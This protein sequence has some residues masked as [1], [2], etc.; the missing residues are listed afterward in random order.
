MS[1]HR[2]GGF[3]DLASDNAASSLVMLPVPFSPMQ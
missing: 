1:L 2:A 3:D